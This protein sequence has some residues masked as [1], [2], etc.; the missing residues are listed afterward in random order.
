MKPQLTAAF[1]NFVIQTP[2]SGF[3]TC[4]HLTTTELLTRIKLGARCHRGWLGI[5][6]PIGSR[7]SLRFPKIE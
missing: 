2:V 4:C 5:L 1:I 3:Y 7:A 6:G